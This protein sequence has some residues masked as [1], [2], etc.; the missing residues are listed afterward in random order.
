MANNSPYYEQTLHNVMLEAVAQRD[1]WAEYTA[2]MDTT[3]S[4][5]EF[6]NVQARTY[7]HIVETILEDRS[8]N[9]PAE[10]ILEATLKAV[11][12]RLYLLDRGELTP[13]LSWSEREGETMALD[14]VRTVIEEES[15][16]GLPPTVEVEES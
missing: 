9:M 14:R 11:N 6:F 1:M 13:D 10:T 5:G 16:I 2:P 3:I 8:Q 7:A 15:R 12:E 4:P